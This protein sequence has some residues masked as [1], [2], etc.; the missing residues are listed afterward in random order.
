MLGGVSMRSHRASYIVNN[1]GGRPIP[2]VD[3]GG[4]RLVVRHLCPKQHK[5]CVNPL[6]LKLGTAS[7]NSF[8]DRIAAGTLPTGENAANNKISE[9]LAQEIKNSLR[10][11]GH[12]GYMTNKR[13]AE[14]FGAS[15]KMVSRIDLNHT[16]SHLPDRFGIVNPNSEFRCKRRERRRRAQSRQWDPQDFVSAGKKLK[17]CIMES[18][19]GKAGSFP[20]GPCHIWKKSTVGGYGQI[21]FKGKKKRAHVLAIESVQKRFLKHTEVVRHLCDNKLC[22]NPVHLRVGTQQENATDIQLHSSSKSFKVDTEK[23]REIR[24]STASSAELAK[25]Y[26]ICTSSV[27]NIRSRR[28]WAE[29]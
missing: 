6:H 26:G 3:K 11:K 23:V 22:I 21:S 19:E 1:N 29:V 8:E 15:A 27:N 17:T 20:P 25:V 16:W 12:P 24:V 7:Q 14:T 5:G 28:T 18:E 9:A 13:R 4:N 10:P 2:Y